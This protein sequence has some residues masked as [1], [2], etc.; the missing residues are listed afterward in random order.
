MNALDHLLECLAASATGAELSRETQR[1]LCDAVARV[2]LLD[3]PPSVAF[4][5]SSR[6]GAGTRRQLVTA[7][8]DDLLRRAWELTPGVSAW[9]RSR[10]LA[11][12]LQRLHEGRARHWYTSGA[13]ALLKADEAARWSVLDHCHQHDL[14]VPRARQ[15][16]VIVQSGGASD[17]TQAAADFGQLKKVEELIDGAAP[18]REAA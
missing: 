6:G 17:C 8:R 10:K 9:D 18:P 1:F 11:A 13:P 2:I 12:A 14:R 7:I 16:H 5:F 15:I 4:G 3:E